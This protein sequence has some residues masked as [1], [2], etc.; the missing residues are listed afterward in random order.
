ME[1]DIC[2]DLHMKFLWLFC[3]Y[4]HCRKRLE[5]SRVGAGSERGDEETE[6]LIK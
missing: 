3:G 2:S 6:S 4:Y 1:E 5:T